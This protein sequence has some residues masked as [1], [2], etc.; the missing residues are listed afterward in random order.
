M[1][2][3]PTLSI[4]VPCYNVENYLSQCLLSIQNQTFKD[5]EVICLND[6][7][8]D[9]TLSILKIVQAQDSRFK[10]I[11]KTNSG[12]GDSMNLG[13][14]RAKG[15]Y[16]GIVESD[17]YV[18]NRM[19]EKL[20]KE[21]EAK[22]LDVSRCGYFLSSKE[23]ITPVR[24]D[25][26]KKNTVFNPNVDPS[27]FWQAP[28]IWSAIYKREWLLRNGIGFLP[29][30]GASYQDTSFA[31]K[32]YA[33][34]E[35]FQMIPETLLFYRTDNEQSSVNNKA[36]AFCVCAEWKEIYE[37]VKR[38]R[39]RFGH[40]LPLLPMLQYGTYRWNLNRISSPKLK[41]FFSIVWGTECVAHLLCGDY[42][43]YSTARE[44]SRKVLNKLKTS[45][46]RKTKVV[47]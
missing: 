1:K 28:A 42:P 46:R 10:I 22:N 44:L 12:Y 36:K 25:W 37:F 7:S 16:I 33:C 24:N 20:V 29:T 4:L 15:K 43:L 38:D 9:S 45:V 18:D 21:A 35:R 8:T 41:L 6:G 5:F 39:K 2:S 19:F 23:G 26:I 27:P 17:D 47:Q 3:E 40:L 13:L 30:P 31:F 34:C 32:C 14:Q 11:D